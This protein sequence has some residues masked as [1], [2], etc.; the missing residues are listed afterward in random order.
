L[1]KNLV[2]SLLS[3]VTLVLG[4]IISFLLARNLSLDEFG[5]Y[6]ISRNLLALGILIINFGFDRTALNYLTIE[7]VNQNKYIYSTKVI[8]FFLVT[9]II[10]FSGILFG[11]NQSTYL[12][13]VSILFVNI[14]DIKYL[15]DLNKKIG[16]EVIIQLLK[17][18]PGLIYIV[19]CNYTKKIIS[20]NLFF[21]FLLVGHFIVYFLHHHYINIYPKFGFNKNEIKNIFKK[22]SPAFTGI[23]IS[24]GNNFFDTFIILFYI[25]TK[26]LAIYSIAYSIYSGLIVFFGTLA[27][28]YISS[29]LNSK[30][31]LKEIEKF[32]KKMF[33]VSALFSIPL[34]VF[35]DYIIIFILGEKYEE[36]ILIFRI[37]LFSFVIVST[38]LVYG[39]LL[40]VNGNNKQYMYSMLIT[41]IVNVF[42]NII[43]IPF[44]GIIAAAIS[45]V[46]CSIISFIFSYKYLKLEIQST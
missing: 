34:F 35:A 13:I 30:L 11:I 19:Y 16:A 26:Q 21:T 32:T 17:P 20:L 5:I 14:F 3:Q 27:R 29:V 44:Y 2:V 28:Y 23:L 38:S 39:N 45:T 46:I 33:L 9:L 42:L 15:F 10:I 7:T 18:I 22:Y 24:F 6:S 41:T 4:F 1:K 25:N 8:L 12:I 43:L 36:S 37:L 40:L 31:D